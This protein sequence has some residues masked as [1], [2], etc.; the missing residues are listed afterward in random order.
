MA[1]YKEIINEYKDLPGG[2]IES[3]HALQREYN[4][5]PEEAVP[6]AASVFNVSK[7]KA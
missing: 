1:D 2:P 3:Y 7:A 6:Y 5:I 4:Y